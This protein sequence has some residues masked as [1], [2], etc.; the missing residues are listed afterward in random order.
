M[1]DPSYKINRRIK[2]DQRCDQCRIPVIEKETQSKSSLYHHEKGE[3]K[4]LDIGNDYWNLR[5]SVITCE[6]LLL[7]IL[8]FDFQVDLPFTILLTWVNGILVD[9]KRRECFRDDLEWREFGKQFLQDSSFY[10]NQWFL[11]I[12]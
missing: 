12:E 6:L 9:L 2:K 7:R 8:G 11:E 10:A 4:I 1:Y 5:D 3:S